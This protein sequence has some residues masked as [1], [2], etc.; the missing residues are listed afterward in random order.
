M[1]CLATG[2]YFI[3]K[4]KQVNPFNSNYSKWSSSIVI[5]LI[6]VAGILGSIFLYQKTLNV[7]KSGLL[8]RSNTIA[9]LI[10]PDAVIKLSGTE[11]DIENQTYQEL[12]ADL[13]KAR[14]ESRDVRFFYL[15]GRRDGSTFFLVDSE[16]PESTSYSAPG[17]IYIFPSPAIDSAF[18]KAAAVEG[19]IRDS[20]GNW[21]SSISPIYDKEGNVIAVFGAD[22]DAVRY[23]SSARISAS[24][25]F[26]I[27]LILILILSFNLSL[28]R[29][30]AKHMDAIQTK[31][32]ANNDSL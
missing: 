22:V 10:D 15:M 19:P 24:I 2:V 32:K 27:A 13:M 1:F 23:V 31:L 14:T 9:S 30:E 29:K 6:A 3:H 8:Q 20:F 17:D 25:P 16:V 26:F 12:K 28:K 7:N 5:A 11:A 4:M 18:N 21:I